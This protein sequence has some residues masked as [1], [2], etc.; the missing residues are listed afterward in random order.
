MQDLSELEDKGV[1]MRIAFTPTDLLHVESKLDLWDKDAA[2]FMC[3]DL[4]LWSGRTR[5]DFIAY[6]R[7]V[8]ENKLAW[9]CKNSDNCSEL[10]VIGVG[11]PSHAWLPGMA[12][13]LKQQLCLPEHREVANAIGAAVASI[14]ESA[15]GL[16]R[17]NSV[18][19][20]YI[21]FLPNGRYEFEDMEQAK[22]FARDEL[23][24]YVSQKAEAS[25]CDDAKLFVT[26][27]ETEAQDCFIEYEIMVTAE[28]KSRW[29]A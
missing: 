13:I 12:D 10:P 9:C 16:V 26:E 19:D 3:D 1:L 2:L 15:K 5:S 11:A 7:S 18:N 17:Y 23:K 6:C 8:I 24:K 20:I 29:I 21:L 14:S 4:T 28:G 22:E 25:G 27:D